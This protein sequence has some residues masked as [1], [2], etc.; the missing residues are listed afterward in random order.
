MRSEHLT[1]EMVEGYRDRT[2]G[3]ADLL[4]VTE[5]LAVCEECRRT[6]APKHVEGKLVEAFGGDH[7]QYESL[8][9]I[10][11]GSREGRGHIQV[12]EMCAA[13]LEDLRSFQA[14]L[15]VN[16]PAVRTS[17]L[18][19]WAPLGGLAAVAAVA[20]LAILVRPGENRDNAP[21]T[22]PKQVTL[23]A[24]V[25]DSG[26]LISLDQAGGVGGL[27]VLAPEE[28]GRIGD[29]LRTG[30]LTVA[31]GQDL[32]R[33][34]ETLLGESESHVSLSPVAPIGTVVSSDLP[35]FRWQAES[36]ANRFQVRI[37]DE[38]FNL[39]V[40]SPQTNAH[41]WTP[42][43]ALPRGETLSWTVSAIEGGKKVTAPR[44]PEPEARF[45]VATPGAAAE[46]DAIRHA[47]P[48]SELRIA[49][50]AAQLGMLDEAREALDQLAASN[51]GSELI[52]R[53]RTSLSGE[54][55][56]KP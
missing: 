18:R 35:T 41:E 2:L 1:A 4:S 16:A 38:K 13:E 50:T 43:K 6:V 26:R 46:M 49:I 19:I 5:H 53:L 37:Y 9:A 33:T 23:M 34:R 28:R 45:R 51:P 15:G 14:G 10:V 20:L 21:V 30:R 48:P 42:D 39:V 44:A 29:V 25:R 8:E 7:V 56:K 54:L 27:G 3:P 11:L 17:G 55:T 52:A 47:A 24:S 22:T 32:L 12:C 31:A 36:D 40:E